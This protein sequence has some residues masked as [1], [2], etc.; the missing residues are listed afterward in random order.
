LGNKDIKP[1]DERNG[2]VVSILVPE[3]NVNNAFLFFNAKDRSQENSPW[4]RFYFN[5]SEFI[6]ASDKSSSANQA[7]PSSRP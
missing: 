6:N 4:H 3:D 7:Q 2:I 5:I 1:T